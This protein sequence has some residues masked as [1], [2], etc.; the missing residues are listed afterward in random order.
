MHCLW[1]LSFHV[2]AATSR[3]MASG[4]YRQAPT[5]A[6]MYTAQPKC[7]KSAVMDDHASRSALLE[8][9][10]WTDLGS[11]IELGLALF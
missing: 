6:T 1:R 11:T 10:A 7:C 8:R 9:E 2:N 4:I 5:P 3:T